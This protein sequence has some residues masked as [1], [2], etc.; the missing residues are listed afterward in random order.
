MFQKGFSKIWIFLIVLVV[1]AGGVLVWQQLQT[2]PE[3][4]PAEQ[5]ANVS[6]YIWSLYSD[7]LEG[8]LQIEQNGQ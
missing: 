2:P 8:K 7:A 1:I 4:Q 6:A 3:E 5:P